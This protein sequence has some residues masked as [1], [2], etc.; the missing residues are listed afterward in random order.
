MTKE[1]GLDGM[2]LRL[3]LYQIKYIYDSA[4]NFA[5]RVGSGEI[6]A[7]PETHEEV[8]STLNL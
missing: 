4:K 8:K 2:Y 5:K 3:V 7:K 6:E 1:H